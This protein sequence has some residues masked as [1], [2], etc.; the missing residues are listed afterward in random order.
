MFLLFGSTLVV[1]IKKTQESTPIILTEIRLLPF[2]SPLSSVVALGARLA[3]AGPSNLSAVGKDK[4]W[5]NLEHNLNVLDEQTWPTGRPR[6]ASLPLDYHRNATNRSR[7]D[8]S[9]QHSSSC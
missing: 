5:L 2:D 1:K 7:S 3:T 9:A 8:S 6:R 4:G